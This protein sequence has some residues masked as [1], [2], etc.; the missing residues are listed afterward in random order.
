MMM[1]SQFFV[2]KGFRGILSS[3]CWFLFRALT[4]QFQ[5]DGRVDVDKVVGVF[6]VEV[7]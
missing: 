3:R 1:Y 5:Q 2:Q 4:R 7:S 6:Q